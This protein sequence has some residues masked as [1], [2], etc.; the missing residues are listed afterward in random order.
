[1]NSKILSYNIENL[2][3]IHKNANKQPMFVYICELLDNSVNSFKLKAGNKESN[4]NRIYL[5]LNLHKNNSSHIFIEDNG[6]GFDINDCD[7]IFPENVGPIKNNDDLNRYNI[8]LKDS[9]IVLSESATNNWS[10]KIYSY[11]SKNS[12]PIIIDSLDK[13]LEKK[14]VKIIELNINEHKVKGTKIFIN[15]SEKIV[16]DNIDNYKNYWWELILLIF[17]KY[18]ILFSKY[19]IN[20]YFNICINEKNILYDKFEQKNEDFNDT[21]IPYLD[22]LIK[23]FP[24]IILR[25]YNPIWINS[26]PFCNFLTNYISDEKSISAQENKLFGDYIRYILINEKSYLEKRYI[27]LQEINE[28]KSFLDDFNFNDD[29]E[30]D[31]L[32]W[33]DTNFLGNDTLK[34]SVYIQAIKNNYIFLKDVCPQNFKTWKDF[35]NYV[36]NILDKSINGKNYFCHELKQL[37]DIDKDKI[38][39]D[40]KFFIKK[41]LKTI[42]ENAGIKIYESQRAIYYSPYKNNYVEEI[43]KTPGKYFNSNLVN[44]K[45]HLYKW[46]GSKKGSGTSVFHKVEAELFFSEIPNYFTI[47]MNKTK[48]S[49]KFDNYMQIFFGEPDPN[50]EIVNTYSKALKVSSSYA[51]IVKYLSE[52]FLIFSLFG[53]SENTSDYSKIQN[54]LSINDKNSNISK[55]IMLGKLFI[56]VN[57]D[58]NYILIKKDK[59]QIIGFM[60]IIDEQEI[61]K[62]GLDEK[63]EMAG[64]ISPKTILSRFREF[65]NNDKNS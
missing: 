30:N 3:N 12:N 23:I 64:Y 56:D 52:Y 55:N 36:F 8:G 13:N 47:D 45:K 63:Y 28:L 54:K 15:L 53:L 61:K 42:G 29:S 4:S 19:Q 62:Y 51:L 46:S 41:N 11:K 50:E 27:G 18:H 17:E 5:E 31:F 39:V 37:N 60:K 33:L 26:S 2:L 35:K 65:S 14:S 34:E 32:N 58:D 59:N 20:F 22:D 24:N 44:F 25:N 38:K 1:M 57:T 9:L 21:Q 10:F 49:E 40:F 16:L 43:F 6:I 7:K 48:F